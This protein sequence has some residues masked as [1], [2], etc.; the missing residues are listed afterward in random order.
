MDIFKRLKVGM[1]DLKLVLVPR[2]AER[3]DEV[4]AVLEEAG[5]NFLRKTDLDSGKSSGEADVLLADTTGEIRGFYAIA[6]VVFVGK[7][8]TQHGGQNFI[9]PALSAKPILVGPNLENFPVVEKEFLEAKAMVQVQDAGEL[10]REL[11]TLLSDKGHRAVLSERAAG[12]VQLKSGAAR[13]VADKV[14]SLL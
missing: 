13:R 10:E 11:K 3:R 6:D 14:L 12:L 9:E 7:S 2:H 5:L 1:P 8:L 4:S